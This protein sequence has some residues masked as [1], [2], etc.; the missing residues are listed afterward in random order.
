[1]NKPHLVACPS[2][3]RHVRVSEVACP[4][5]GAVLA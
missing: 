5:C 4:F 1:M 2:C 3:A